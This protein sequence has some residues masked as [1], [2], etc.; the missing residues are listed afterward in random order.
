MFP[1]DNSEQI[2]KVSSTPATQTATT[3]LPNVLHSPLFPTNISLPPQS[4]HQPQHPPL[5]CPSSHACLS[6]HSA[7]GTACKSVFPTFQHN[8]SADVETTSSSSSASSN[9]ARVQAASD[10]AFADNPVSAV[11]SLLAVKSPSASLA[12]LN[13]IVDFSSYPLQQDI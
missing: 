1:F 4:A 5:P 2:A 12:G 13:L 10:S 3:V 9:L 6:N 11:S 7:A 8:P